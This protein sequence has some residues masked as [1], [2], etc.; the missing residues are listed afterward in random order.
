MA[1]PRTFYG[2][3]ADGRFFLSTLSASALNRPRNEYETK[4]DAEVAAKVRNRA[5]IEWESNV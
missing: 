1:K 3:E 4:A 5:V 2:W